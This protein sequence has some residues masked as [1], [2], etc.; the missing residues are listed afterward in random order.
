MDLFTS[1][2]VFFL[3]NLKNGPRGSFFPPGFP[4]HLLLLPLL[5]MP[6][7]KLYLICLCCLGS[8]FSQAD[9]LDTHCCRFDKPINLN[10]WSQV[11]EDDTQ[12]RTVQ[13]LAA[14][15]DWFISPDSL[16]QKSPI[17][18]YWLKTAI[19]N[20]GEE[21]KVL[22]LSFSNL[23]YV[24]LYEW[25]GDSLVLS[26]KGGTFRPV[27]E[28]HQGDARD[29]FSLT[30]P[31]HTVYTLFLKVHHTKHYWPG[32]RFYLQDGFAFRASLQK[33]Q[34]IDLW[35][36]GAISIFLLYS[37]LSWVVSF[38]RFYLWLVL[39]IAASGLY[40][41]SMEG[42]FID[43]FTPEAPEAGWLWNI[44]LIHA[45]T[46][47][48]L[49]LVIDFWG[50][51]S[52]WPRLYR[53]YIIVIIGQVIISLIS[54]GI[55]LLT[56]NFHLMN[57]INLFY[58]GCCVITAFYG[59]IVA[60]PGL[61]RPGRILGYGYSLYLT[62]YAVCIILFSLFQERAIMSITYVGNFSIL[63]VI[64]LFSTALKEELH[65]H[66]ADK[67][68]ALLQLNEL[69]QQ[70]N[71]GLE[72]LILERTHDLQERNNSIETLMQELHHRVKNNL[73]LLYGLIR[74]QLPEIKDRSAKDMMQN[75]LNRIRAMSIVNEKLFQSGDT[76]VVNL[77][78][79][80][81]E[82]TQH[83]STMYNGRGAVDLQ[84]VIAADIT[85]PVHF[86]V[87]FGLILT[88]LLTN[89]FKYAFPDNDL[90]A[91]GLFV[92]LSEKRQ[93]E[94]RYNDNGKGYSLSTVPKKGFSGLSL[95]RD[96]AR[97]LHGSMETW[98][99][100]G[101]YYKFLMPV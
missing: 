50:M 25:A 48:G 72:Q 97:Q 45:G 32:L 59:L 27:R 15:P 75:N 28:I 42:Y 96:L 89:S 44:H 81:L 53:L 88:E 37:L 76:S 82:T 39:F 83:V 87:P 34:M 16:H 30:I 99:E 41:L 38:H 21:P 64:I 92:S 57:A 10:H 3:L 70:Q 4:L 100:D 95:V 74:L 2:K 84:L 69:Q 86:A 54:L 13:Q 65:K 79:F 23:S 58:M 18:I 73:Q 29:F 11:L 1:S 98:Y 17:G 46:I 14:H 9:T 77:H 47:G 63:A 8:F 31:P 19:G 94:L 24:D 40:S 85:V 51:K 5:T 56:G 101:L 43:W 33:K 66:E 55:D 68:K 78:D 90:P 71:Q 60:W 6:K 26:R 12:M 49:L 67:N 20:S 22:I 36:L 35:I 91:I 62:G 52:N 7:V 80:V 93:L 61:S